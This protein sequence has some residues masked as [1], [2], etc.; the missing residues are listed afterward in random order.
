MTELMRRSHSSSFQRDILSSTSSSSTPSIDM[1]GGDLESWDRIRAI[2]LESSV[3]L[4]DSA[5]AA[6]ASCSFAKSD[7]LRNIQ[8]MASLSFISMCCAI[9]CIFSSSPRSSKSYAFRRPGKIGAYKLNRSF[10][11]STESKS[12]ILGARSEA[13]E[14]YISF[15][16]SGDN[17]TS[18]PIGRTGYLHITMRT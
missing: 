17:S 16:S 12:L 15:R 4:K 9:L 13:A 14:R 18:S 6:R 2:I 1:V 7:W 3:L 8:A 5:L 11:T 10:V